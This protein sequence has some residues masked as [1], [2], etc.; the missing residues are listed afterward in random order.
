MEIT[1]ELSAGRSC[2]EPE[3]VPTAGSNGW[4][5]C[6][7]PFR[8]PQF[9]TIHPRGKLNAAP[10]GFFI[11]SDFMMD[12]KAIIQLTDLQGERCISIGE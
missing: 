6:A 4:S 9:L 5:E 2:P 1:R 8:M 11:G 3:A 12:L 7:A 10:A